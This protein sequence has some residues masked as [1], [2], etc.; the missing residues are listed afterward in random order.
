MAGAIVRVA[1]GVAKA[2][3]RVGRAGIN[4][5][6]KV[7]GR[8]RSGGSK[9]PKKGSRSTSQNAPARKKKVRNFKQ[10]VSNTR[11][12]GSKKTGSQTKSKSPGEKGKALKKRS[13]EQRQNRR[14]TKEKL[15]NSDE[16]YREEKKRINENPKYSSEEKE[17]RV[18]RLREEYNDYQRR[19]LSNYR[20]RKRNLAYASPRGYGNNYGYG[21]LGGFAVG[22]LAGSI[23]SS[24]VYAPQPLIYGG[25]FPQASRYGTFA[26]YPPSFLPGPAQ[27]PPAQ[28]TF[29]PTSQSPSESIPPFNSKEEPES[30]LAPFDDQE[31][32]MLAHHNTI[33]GRCVKSLQNL[34]GSDFVAFLNARDEYM[35]AR[36][37]EEQRNKG[38]AFIQISKYLDKRYSTH[39]MAWSRVMK[40]RPRYWTREMAQS[41]ADGA[42]A[43]EMEKMSKMEGKEL[44]N[45]LHNYDPEKLDEI[46]QFSRACAAQ[47]I[48]C[49]LEEKPLTKEEKKEE[50]GKSGSLDKLSV[51]FKNERKLIEFHMNGYIRFVSFVTREEAE[52]FNISETIKVHSI[53]AAVKDDIKTKCDNLRLFSNA[54]MLR[55]MIGT[56]LPINITPNGYHKPI[57][58]IVTDATP[59]LTPPGNI[60]EMWISTNTTATNYIKLDPTANI[61]LPSFDDA[62]RKLRNIG[63][64]DLKTMNDLVVTL[65]EIL[66]PYTNVLK[67]EFPT[68][69]LALPVTAKRSVR[70]PSSSST[71]SSSTSTSSSQTAAKKPRV[72]KKEPSTLG[73][74]GLGERSVSS[75]TLSPSARRPLPLSSVRRPLSSSSSTSTSS[76]Q[77]VAKKPRTVAKKP[78]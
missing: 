52:R 47:N 13:P 23:L 67:K 64:T 45:Y 15:R 65:V 29:Q 7:G 66:A 39:A 62:T 69:G 36:D 18:S 4:A 40:Y 12:K 57:N 10:K 1:G 71:S 55:R 21:V 54:R 43:E 3:I 53:R 31:M 77:T 32:R 68:L 37:S 72:L 59:S 27:F 35:A 34:R 33:A 51:Y 38:L 75:S 2:G 16:N 70:S 44:S 56:D 9:I 26:A 8:A 60:P 78:P 17:Q 11:S 19:K 41:F 61:K 28:P 49:S 74:Q 58:N 20:L 25:G 48:G 22:G 73:S 50:A 30:G 5:V 46:Q 6:K 14:S 63:P 24:R 76:S 42:D